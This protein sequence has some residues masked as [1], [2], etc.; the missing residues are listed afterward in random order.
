[1]NKLGDDSYYD[2]DTTAYRIGI[3]LINSDGGYAVSDWL[4]SYYRIWCGPQT[5]DNQEAIVEEHITWINWPDPTQY[6]MNLWRNINNRNR[7]IPSGGYPTCPSKP[8]GSDY[9]VL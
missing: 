2:A 5:D 8:N 7:F 9:S 1:M 3:T 4:V 6:Q